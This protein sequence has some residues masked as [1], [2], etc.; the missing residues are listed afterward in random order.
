MRYFKFLQHSLIL[1]SCAIFNFAFAN[2]APVINA[3]QYENITTGPQG[4]LTLSQRLDQIETQIKNQQNSNS[5]RK[6]QQL[7]E[8][9]QTLTEKLE[10]QADRLVK[11]QKLIEKNQKQL[12][13]TY[14]SC[15]SNPKNILP[16]KNASHIIFS[17]Q[18][19][20]ESAYKKIIQ[21][22][23]QDAMREMKSYLQLYPKGKFVANAYFW[24]GE[25]YLLQDNDRLAKKE[26]KQVIAQYPNSYKTSDAM[27]KLGKISYNNGQL[28]K[29]KNQF[30]QIMKLYPNTTVAQMAQ[31]QLKNIP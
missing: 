22:N 3:Y 16:E 14:L 24:L 4:K 21:K 13:I 25:L 1:L 29:A 28:D 17:D 20:Y 7:Q 12:K 15:R 8:D 27:L 19:A 6:I 26:F 18:S 9:I 30:L 23:Y 2:E 10:L 31:N 5:Q 11:L